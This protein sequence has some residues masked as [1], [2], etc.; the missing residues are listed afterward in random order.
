MDTKENMMYE[1][2]EIA[3][4]VPMTSPM[5]LV[6]LTE[7]IKINGQR[8][9]IL[10]WRE[11]IVD[12]RNRQLACQLLGIKVK[13]KKIN[14]KTS[15]ENVIKL[16]K[17]YN[18]RRNLTETQKVMSA[19]KY[20]ETNGGSNTDV[21]KLWG[22]SERTLKNGKYIAKHREDFVKDLFEGKTV[23]FM[24]DNRGYEIT[25]SKITPIAQYIKINLEKNNLIVD[26]SNEVDL[27]FS[28]DGCIKTEAGKQWFYDRKKM[29]AISEHGMILDYIE[30]A[31]FKFSLKEA[32]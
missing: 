17:S 10:I 20:Q 19:V 28:V 9:P 6:A 7:D 4:M 14:A 30:L 13:V 11:K 18:T 24:D 23:K 22:V 29:F 27:T 15:R 21:A 12:G 3:S 8:E 26:T 16:V 32:S 5:E 2:D 1:I 31:N 25:T